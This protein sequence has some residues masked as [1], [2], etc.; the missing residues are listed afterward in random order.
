MA[1]KINFEHFHYPNFEISF[2]KNKKVFLKKFITFLEFNAFKTFLKLF[3][4]NEKR[5]VSIQN[6]FFKSQCQ[7]KQN[8]ECKMDLSQRAGFCH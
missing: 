3:Y 6:C 5:H 1:A 8:G 4:Y 7:D 2:L